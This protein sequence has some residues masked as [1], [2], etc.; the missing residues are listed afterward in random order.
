L[1]E[2]GLTTAFILVRYQETRIKLF[3]IATNGGGVYIMESASFE[4]PAFEPGLKNE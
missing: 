1:G 2:A 4:N 3:G